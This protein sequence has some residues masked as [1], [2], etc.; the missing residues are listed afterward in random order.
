ML[1][2]E[3]LLTI[4]FSLCFQLKQAAEEAK[5]VEEEERRLLARLESTRATHEKAFEELKEAVLES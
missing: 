1:R 2:S 3:C 4:A 5:R